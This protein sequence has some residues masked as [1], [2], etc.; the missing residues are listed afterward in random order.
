MPRLALL[1]AAPLALLTLCA[2]APAAHASAA[3]SAQLLKHA[4]A[5]GLSKFKAFQARPALPFPRPL[6]FPVSWYLLRRVFEERGAQWGCS[7]RL[8]CKAHAAAV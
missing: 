2:L 1:L 3:V 7:L 8:V 4:E 5:Q 6:L